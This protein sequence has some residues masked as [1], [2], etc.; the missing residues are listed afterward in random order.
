MQNITVLTSPLRLMDPAGY[1][2]NIVFYFVKNQ[3]TLLF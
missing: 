1:T 3:Y 2:L